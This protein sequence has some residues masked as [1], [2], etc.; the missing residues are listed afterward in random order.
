MLLVFES[1]KKGSLIQIKTIK[2]SQI[3]KNENRQEHEDKINSN[4][5]E[6]NEMSINFFIDIFTYWDE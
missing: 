3:I 2:L 5:Y 4:E 1:I 6:T